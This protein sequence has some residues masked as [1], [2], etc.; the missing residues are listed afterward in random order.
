[1]ATSRIIA[2]DWSGARTGA[3]RK[4]WLAEV[5][6][7]TLRRLESG[8]GREA[9]TRLLIDEAE[10]DLDLVVGLDF[11]FSFPLWYFRHRGLDAVQSLWELA[12][13]EG[14]RWLADCEPPFW[15]RPGRGRPDH[16]GFR[17]TDLDVRGRYSSQPKSPFQIGGAGAVGT[18]SIRGMPFLAA[19][20]DAG[21]NIWPFDPPR[22]PLVVEIYPRLLTGDLVKS[23]PEARSSHMRG[24]YPEIGAR[25]RH[26]AT[27]SEDALD[28]AVSAV[29]MARHVDEILALP[30]ARDDHE[31]LEGRI[32]H[33]PELTAPSAGHGSSTARQGQPEPGCPFC[34]IVA[35]EASLSTGHVVAFRDRYPLSEGHT[36]VVP[37]RHVA[38][39]SDL[40]AEEEAE[41]W[42]LVREVREDLAGSHDLDGFNIGVNDGEAAGQTVR[43]AHVHVIPRRRGDVPD[44][45]GGVRWVIPDRAPYWEQDG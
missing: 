40:T 28:A 8:R 20:K 14:E 9:L 34:E 44:P 38:S 25:H 33:P 45:R 42:A 6:H 30:P 22:P 3:A 4:I 24:A 29:V 41:L 19:L 26:L 43:H 12:A 16:E 21:F 10:Q 35:K 11:A 37:A 31:R 15:G 17:R 1:M 18:M 13:D 7:G 2:V 32:W 36:L 39:L 23:D 27:G 5:A